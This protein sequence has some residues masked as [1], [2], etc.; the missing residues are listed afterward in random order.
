M[1]PVVDLFAGPGGLGEGFSAFSPANGSHKFR[2][3]LSIEMEEWAHQTLELRS[4]FRQFPARK[5]PD[6]YYDHLRARLARSELLARFPKEAEVA[7]DE[8]WKAE[9]GVVPPSEVDRRIRNALDGAGSW[10]LCG[11]PPCQAFSVVGR[12]RSGGI[13]EDD[14]RVYLYKQYLRILSVHEPPVFIMENVKGLLSSQVNGSEIFDQML[15]DLRHPA[16]VIRGAQRAGAKYSLHSLFLKPSSYLLDGQPH[17]NPGDFVIKCEDYGIPQSRHRVIILGIRE[18]LASQEI[19]VLQTGDR[20]IPASKVVRGL[21]RL[22]SGLTHSE[23]GK[24]EWRAALATI[25]N[26]GFMKSRQNG[27][28]ADLRRYIARTVCNLRDMQAD[29]GGE[30]VL[31]DATCEYDPEWFLDPR[32]GGVCNHSSRPHMVADLHRYLF[33]ACFARVHFRSPEL[34]DFPPEL[35]PHHRNLKD[36]LSRGYFDDRFRVQMAY[37]PAT[38]I[39]SHIAKDGHYFIHYDETQCR[40]LTVREAARIQTFPDNYYFCGPRTHQYRQVG[41]AVPPLLARQIAAIALRILKGRRE[42]AHVGL[43]EE[44]AV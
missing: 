2:I 33:A 23:D 42:C 13:A 37:R 8:A 43:A 10:I 19:P 31:H 17:C 21:P 20:P 22:R 44:A 32:I 4:F 34:N 16:K 5:V 30:F 14:H 9:L 25:L 28:D 40:S 1:V 39:T 38:T 29:R 36:A 35:H 27:V 15:D 26:A 6:E 3:A 24:A 7:G 41:N 12:S 18:D 11:G